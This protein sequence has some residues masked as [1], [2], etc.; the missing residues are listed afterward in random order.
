MDAMFMQMANTALQSVDMAEF[1]NKQQEQIQAVADDDWAEA[2][3]N[4]NMEAVQ[5]VDMGSNSEEGKQLR[6]E[7]AKNYGDDAKVDG[8]TITYTDES[9]ETQTVELT[10]EQFKTQYAAMK[11]N[12][13]MARRL[14]D[15]PKAINKVSETIGAI[16]ATFGGTNMT[17]EDQKAMGE[18][19]TK[20][21]S[22]QDGKTLTKAD[23]DA[24]T[25]KDSK[26]NTKRLGEDATGK[27][28]IDS[29]SAS[30]IQLQAM[31]MS[32]SESEQKALG[33]YET[34]VKRI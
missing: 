5:D 21:F 34:F 4:E 25:Y 22:A 17:S 14:E 7:V 6:N 18:A 20:I 23:L 9:G 30:G 12:E 19:V 28:A 10:D 26:G 2:I 32:L 24:L 16:V 31:W 13:D 3:Y 27:F 1:S 29:L 11:A 33:D 8:N 15:I